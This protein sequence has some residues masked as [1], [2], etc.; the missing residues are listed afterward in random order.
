MVLEHH[1]VSH[2]WT[3]PD[4]AVSVLWEEVPGVLH[5]VTGFA[6]HVEYSKQPPQAFI[7]FLPID[8]QSPPLTHI[9]IIEIRD[10]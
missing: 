6:F 9:H 10:L 7:F 4:F 8:K 1:T 5:T 3:G 2:S